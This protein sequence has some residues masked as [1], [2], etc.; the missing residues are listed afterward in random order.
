MSK[1]SGAG[2][3]GISVIICCY[4]SAVRLPETLRHLARQ[5]VPASMP[6]EVILVNNASTD[7]TAEAAKKIWTE[8]EATLPLAVVPE[9]RPGLSYA[10][11]KGI[12]A[13]R[14]DI[15]VFVD[16]DNWLDENYVRVAHE[17]MCGNAAIGVLGGYIKAQCETPA[18]PWFEP[19]QAYYAVGKQSRHSG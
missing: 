8:L 4:N 17:K 16:D 10:R 3:A 7:D 18:P 5:V 9:P 6:W 14:Y 1:G 13:A 11:E 19:L 12:A 2:M 15:L